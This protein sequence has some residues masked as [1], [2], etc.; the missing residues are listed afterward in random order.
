MSNPLQQAK[1][2]L[3]EHY[4][5]YV[6]IVNEHPHECELE[7]NN[8]FAAHGLLTWAKNSI[9][10]FYCESQDDEEDIEIVWDEDDEDSQEDF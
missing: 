3:G 2:I 9:D 4:D 7:Y 5:N 8:S 10:N 1:A 6:I